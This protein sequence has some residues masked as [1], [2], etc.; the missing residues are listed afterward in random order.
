[1]RT[2]I[3][4]VKLVLKDIFISLDISVSDFIIALNRV[5]NLNLD[6]LKIK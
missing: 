1:M 6:I 5:Y 4:G 3:A 2:K